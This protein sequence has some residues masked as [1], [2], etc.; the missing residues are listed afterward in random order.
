M[1]WTPWIADATRP[2]YLALVQA[3][4]TDIQN[5]ALQDGDRLPPQRE[6]AEALGVT[7]ATITKAFREAIQRGIVTART[8]SGT[9]VRIGGNGIDATE[10]SF[11]LSLNN[12]PSRP[13]KPFLDEALHEIGS[14]RS[15]ETL[16][17]YTP[18]SGTDQQRANM[19]KW[20]RRRGLT[21]PSSDVLLT[22]GGQHG[23]AACFSALTQ[24]GDTVLCERWTYTGIRRLAEMYSVK[25]E[26]VAM[27]AEGL[28]PDQ[29]ARKF[30]STSAKLL[31]CTASVQNPTTASMSAERRR[32]IVALCQKHSA[33]MVEDDI[34]GALSSD[35]TPPLAALA[36]QSVIHISSLSKCLAPG[37]R[38]GA[39]LAPEKYQSSLREALVTLQWTGPTLWAELFGIMLENG[40]AERCV[41]AN[42]KEALKRL[43]LYTAVMRAKPSTRLA[44]YH[45]WQAVPSS[46]QLD[47]LVSE[48]LAV[49]VR[50]SPAHHFATQEDHGNDRWI[51]ICLGGGDN[52][53]ALKSQL[54]KLHSVLTSKP[55]FSTTIA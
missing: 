23:L 38:L 53:D 39:I 30:A 14:R 37:I 6:I 18:A 49:G 19:A 13:A 1:S 12:V 9:F 44:S 20:L 29:L 8:G 52:I 22:H 32:A 51:R 45:V 41:I 21:A 28:V 24:P 10:P 27:D 36:P 43:E 55:K 16:C 4:E 3:L 17:C 35:E 48:L 2:K 5:G 50:V 15:S 54:T 11:D 26:G 47:N 25:I 34:Y 46:W 42:Q 31:I 7:I 40:S 33:T